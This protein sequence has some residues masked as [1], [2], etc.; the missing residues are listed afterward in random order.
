MHAFKIGRTVVVAL[1]LGLQA[2]GCGGDGDGPTPVDPEPSV[3]TTLVVASG[4]GQQADAGEAVAIAPAVVVRD[5]QGAPMAGVSVAF[6]VASGGGSLEGATPITNSS[7]IA[8]VSRWIL[9]PAGEQRVTA[10]VAALAPVEFQATITPG[11]EF[12]TGTIGSVGGAITIDDPN[13]AYH[14]LELTAPAGVFSSGTSWRLRVGAVSPSFSAPA[15]FTVSGPPLVIETDAPRGDGLMTLEIPVAAE[16]DE[17]VFF[18]LHDPV[19]GVSELLTTVQ[20]KAGSVVVATSHLRGDLLPDTATIGA[21]PARQGSPSDDP[22]QVLKISIDLMSLQQIQKSVE[23]NPWPVRTLDSGWALAATAFSIAAAEASR[24][25][26][27]SSFVKPLD[28]PGFYAEPG[29][30]AAIQIV[31]EMLADDVRAAV[32][33][34]EPMLD[35]LPKDERDNLV[36]Q[37]LVAWMHFTDQPPMFAFRT[38]DQSAIGA[39]LATSADLDG[40]TIELSSEPGPVSVPIGAVGYAP[41]TFA[42]GGLV[43]V[44]SSI[45]DFSGIESVL[46]ELVRMT[47]SVTE[48]QAANE[49][50]ARQAG[51]PPITPEIRSVTTESWIQGDLSSLIARKRNAEIRIAG[52]SA[53][54]HLPDGTEV[55]RSEGGPVSIIDDLA[56][57]TSSPGTAVMRTI[58]THVVGDDGALR[59]VSVATANVGYA[60]FEVT[61]EEV[62][63]TSQDLDVDLDASVALPPEEGFRVDW[64]WGDGQTSETVD[65]TEASHT[66]EQLGAYDVVARL[67]DAAGTQVLAVDTVR[68][69]EQASAWLGE[70]S[71]TLTDATPGFS[72]QLQITATGVRFVP[73]ISDGSFVV[74]RI[75]AG[76][77]TLVNNVPCANYVSPV[78][79]VDLATQGGI[80]TQWLDTVGEDP[81]APV[82]SEPARGL[83]YRA[84]AFANGFEILTRGC[85]TAQ[86]PDPQVYV[87]STAATWI[88]TAPSDD[89]AGGWREAP[90]PDVLEG[91]FTRQSGNVTETWSWRFV[92]QGN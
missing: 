79:Q 28:I 80:G 85:V 1:A 75:A 13:S 47:V 38:P 59:Q 23:S 14:G 44:G 9:G 50:L 41:F 88:A 18:A 71:G 8:S 25:P 40:M 12:T 42:S 37:N 10:Q 92:R 39:A 73:E 86:N 3:A 54:F 84:G 2:T 64:N 33:N 43:P 58:S 56:V 83:W 78:V 69:R 70:V 74:H 31:E 5:A 49:A 91:T 62:T 53:S 36:H 21:A 77:L 72:R 30:L 6:S 4:Q 76:A 15:G 63:L 7:G 81:N 24:A 19:R 22:S 34:L 60:P 32:E 45:V 90:D 20:R 55:A 11:T 65:A 29:P 82:G 87:I 52:Q 48:R 17:L 68:V 66:Y 51:L 26:R 67:L 35:Q 89:S 16:T 57:G 46:T 61:P 27:F